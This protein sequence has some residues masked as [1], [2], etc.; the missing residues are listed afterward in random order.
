[1]SG[2]RIRYITDGGIKCILAAYIYS[3]LDLGNIS[4]IIGKCRPPDE[5]DYTLS[6]KNKHG[7]DSVEAKLLVTSESGLD[8]RAMLKRRYKNFFNKEIFIS[9]IFYFISGKKVVA[10]MTKVKQKKNLKVERIVGNLFFR[11]NVQKNGMN[12][13]QKK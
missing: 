13:Y 4:L 8:F 2:G 3:Y 5:G 10:L 1:M 6:V 7:S 9:K 12:L 11:E